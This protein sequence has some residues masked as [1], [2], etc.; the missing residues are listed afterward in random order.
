MSGLNI[1]SII[2]ARGGSV[3]VPKKNIKLLN[4]KPLLAYAIESS[5]QS[6][7][8]NRII[9]STDSDDIREVA[10]EWGAETP[11]IRPTDISEDVPTED[12]ALHAIQW[13]ADNE[14]YH[15][16]IVV[17]LQ[18]TSPFRKS[19]RIDQCIEV[20]L[21]DESIDSALTINPVVKRP[22][23]MVRLGSEGKI[24]PYTDFWPSRG[25]ALLKF[26]ASQIYEKVFSPNGIVF[27]CR[28]ST[29]HK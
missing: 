27:A 26:P 23:T 7:Y 5:Q 17:C 2:P 3:R 8:V 19:E 6:K 12:V 14:N 9:L 11:F 16:D 21:K 18:P 10:N 22:E 28:S 29:L 20:M 24:S 25:K 13:L 1:I 15:A 4:G